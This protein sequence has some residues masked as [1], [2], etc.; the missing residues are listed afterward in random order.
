M[1]A[2]D[3]LKRKE[4]GLSSGGATSKGTS[5]LDRLRRK[6]SNTSVSSTPKRRKPPVFEPFDIDEPESPKP[7]SGFLGKGLSF[8]DRL[9]DR[10][11][12]DDYTTNVFTNT[13]KLL[14]SR[15]TEFVLPG[16]KAVRDDPI[17]ASQIKVKDLTKPS[18]VG[19]AGLDAV[20][21][22]PKALIKGAVEVPNFATGGALQPEIKFNVPLLGEVTNSDYNIAQ[23][24]AQGEDPTSVVV[25]EKGMALLDILFFSSLASRV[26]T[27]RP[28]TIV[29][30]QSGLGEL[31]TGAKIP[32]THKS[33]RISTAPK[34]T[35][36][37]VPK[38]WMADYK[39][40]GA[41]IKSYNPNNPIVFQLTTVKGVPTAKLIEIKPSYFKLL[42]T[43]MAS[44][45]PIPDSYGKVVHESTR[46]IAQIKKTVAQQKPAVDITPSDP[47]VQ[48]VKDPRSY[49]TAEEFI[50]AQTLSKTLRGTNGL[51]VDDIQ[52]QHPNIRLTKDV[53]AKDIHGNKVVIPDG[54]KLTPYE[55]KGNKVLLQ[56]GVTYIVS[57]NQFQNIKGQSVGGEAKPF[58]PEL[59]G[60]EEIVR[61]DK[62]IMDDGSPVPEDEHFE[63]RFSQYQLPEGKNYREIL[64]TKPV[65]GEDFFTSHAF[66][67]QNNYGW[68]RMNDRTFKGKPVTFLEEI[69]H[70]KPKE[71][72]GTDNITLEQYNALP[73]HMKGNE[74]Y[75]THL[76]RALKDAVDS[77]AEYFSWINGAQTSA[78]YDLATQ[79]DDVKWE[80]RDIFL[81]AKGGKEI[82]ITVDSQGVIERTRNAS[83]DWKGKKL[84]EVLGKGLAD[85]IMSKEKGELSGEGLSFGGE[86]ADNL[87]NKQVGNIVKKLT[88]GKVIEMDLGLP[89]QVKKENDVWV[90]GKPTP[91]LSAEETINAHMI[92]SERAGSIKRGD[93]IFNMTKT[94]YYMVTKILG[95]GKFEVKNSRAMG[96]ANSERSKEILDFSIEETTQQGIKLTPEIKAK[97]R[98]E[99][100]D[101]KTS[102][103]K[104]DT[105]DEARLTDIWNKAQQQDL[106]PAQKNAAVDEFNA[107]DVISDKSRSQQIKEELLEDTKIPGQNALDEAIRA[108]DAND[109]PPNFAPSGQTLKKVFA[110]TNRLSPEEQASYAQ[111]KVN[112]NRS[113]LDAQEIFEHFKSPTPPVVEDLYAYQ[114]G[115]RD[116]RTNVIQKQFDELFKNAAED[117]LSV[118]Y[119]QN[120]LPQVY[121]QTP[122]AVVEAVKKYLIDKGTD[123]KLVDDYVEG[124]AKLSEEAS[125]SLRMT[126]G[127]TKSAAFPNYAVAKEYGLDPKYNDIAQLLAYYKGELGKT[128][129]N[130]KFLEQ[131]IQQGRVK[132]SDNAP[133]GWKEIN[134][135]ARGER[136]YASKDLADVVNGQFRDMADL[137]FGEKIAHRAAQ[138]SKGV[139]ELKLSAG[140]PG[141]SLN[142]FTVGQ[143]VKAMTSGD[144]SGPAGAFLRS[145]SN[146]ASIKYFKEHSAVIREMADNGIDLGKLVGGYKDTYKTLTQSAKDGKRLS[147][148][149]DAFGKAFNEK[150]FNSFMPQMIIESYMKT[151]AGLE[152]GS[153]FKG[154]KDAMSEK[155]AQKLAADTT[156]TFMGL[157]KDTGR[158]GLTHDVMAGTLF[159]PRFRE[160]IVNT[161]VN[162]V[163]GS[164]TQ[165]KN[166]AFSKSRK[167]MMGVIL[168]YF[169]AN[170]L[171]KYL[172]GDPDKDFKDRMEDGHYMYENPEWKKTAIQIPKGDGAVFVDWM[173]TFTGFPKA[174][175]SGAGNLAV[176]NVSE[177]I[178][179]LK[180]A[181]SMPVSMAGELANNKN[182]F[183]NPIYDVD[184]TKGD[185]TA[186]ILFYLNDSVNHPFA[187]EPLRMLDERDKTTIDNSIAKMLELPA[188]FKTQKALDDAEYYRLLEE[189]MDEKVEQ[190]SKMKKLL[191][192]NKKGTKEDA[193]ASVDALTDDQYKIYKEVIEAEKFR[194][195]DKVVQEMYKVLVENQ[196]GSQKDAQKVVDVLADEEYE[197]YQEAIKIQKRNKNAAD[198][199]IFGYDYGEMDYERNVIKRVVTYAHAFGIDF[200]QAWKGAWGNE[201]IEKVDGDLVMFYRM[202]RSRSEQEAYRQL[203]EMGIAP[204]FRS[205]YRLDHTISRELGGDNSPENLRLVPKHVWAM[206]TDFENAL[207]AKLRAGKVTRKK[208]GVL[209]TAFKDGEYT[210]EEFTDIIDNL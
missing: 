170:L 159:A 182:F 69:Q 127:F 88:G 143:M 134:I 56:D 191:K 117:G 161:V 59:K 174:I 203:E 119:K 178:Q 90:A 155:D 188:S 151:K 130:K 106:T 176:G 196:A 20:K 84:D 101:I 7:F 36:H 167:F 94:E 142:V 198:G 55:L 97:I 16:V 58:A 112:E 104:V 9:T 163:R 98:G 180:M 185:K 199:E 14:P 137:G 210:A 172:T 53:P 100:P 183:G 54:E 3:R 103:K 11:E 139:Q 67:D 79:L 64:F 93:E 48:D 141:S 75:I 41:K 27:P 25:G 81:T 32:A 158:S 109:A 35:S 10:P 129:A 83:L 108:E 138:L 148:F 192:K 26:V 206:Y 47:V 62:P 110:P 124:R 164:T 91:G 43:K 8:I 166:P 131:L 200:E 2:L 22:L 113:R 52:K 177:G 34:T 71:L 40:S 204:Y 61:D 184:A 187:A 38:K 44:G 144:F 135:S 92:T 181:L 30:T 165:F 149:S 51:S 168:T 49:K 115:V 125:I 28:K 33:F 87:Y 171:N 156:K 57:K 85:S 140:L 154:R 121:K 80:N 202:P 74:F 162:A 186:Q 15:L 63:T 5:A 208:A 147:L 21:G 18:V 13:L 179:S 12:E 60:T 145:N 157:I 160:G 126:P 19:G 76:K 39:A 89:V 120:Y 189:K 65:G 123:P 99:A 6:E 95:D 37:T 209:I 46:S 197:A 205:E 70:V 78:R 190:E 152:K 118:A 102:G 72:G 96:E 173:P 50:E 45:K 122:E 23:R 111:W 201:N 24:V 73:K 153:L 86:W 66:P 17:A 116:G 82:D 150:T 195:K 107:T 194:K 132:T 114:R 4:S 68:L 193:Q 128:R 31:P 136:F 146:T 133:Q 42:Q 169:F 105:E 1:S 175:V 207:S 77:N 29:K